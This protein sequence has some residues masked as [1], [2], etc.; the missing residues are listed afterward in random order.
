MH[1]RTAKFYDLV[2]YSCVNDVIFAG[3]L[4]NQK[5]SM[6]TG[7]FREINSHFLLNEHGNT[8]FLIINLNGIRSCPI[9]RHFKKS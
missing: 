9:Y 5:I 2:M 8:H 7:L 6:K 3:K 4:E 1:M